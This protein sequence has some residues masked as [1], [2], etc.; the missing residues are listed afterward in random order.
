MSYTEEQFDNDESL[1][2]KVL[3]QHLNLYSKILQKYKEVEG[4]GFEICKTNTGSTVFVEYNYEEQY[5]EMFI[6]EKPLC[7]FTLE[8]D[9]NRLIQLLTK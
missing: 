4:F 9:F 1:I 7:K 3:A 2:D 6:E 8:S 5:F